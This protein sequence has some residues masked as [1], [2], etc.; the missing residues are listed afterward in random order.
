MRK[1]IL[2]CDPGL[3][4]LMALQFLLNRDDV[5]LLAITTVSGN[6][7]AEIGAENAIK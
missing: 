5:D 1:I 3:D 4:D 6:S 2:D 7:E